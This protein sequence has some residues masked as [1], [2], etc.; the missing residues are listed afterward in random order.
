MLEYLYGAHMRVVTWIIFMIVLVTLL[1]EPLSSLAVM[2]G[3]GM[4][5]IVGAIV[6]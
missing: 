5:L 3:V 1:Y 2:I 4:I 6:G